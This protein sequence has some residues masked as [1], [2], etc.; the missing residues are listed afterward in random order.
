MSLLINLIRHKC[1]CLFRMVFQIAL[2]LQTN[3]REGGERALGGK[4]TG[5]IPLC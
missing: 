1:R 2:E 3:T 5:W 4:R